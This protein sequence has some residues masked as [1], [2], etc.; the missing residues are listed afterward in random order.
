LT[1]GWVGS[2]ITADGTQRIEYAGA[3]YPVMARG[4][5]GWDIYAMTATAS[6]GWQRW[7][8]HV[9]RAVGASVGRLKRKGQPELEQL[10]RRP[11]RVYE[12]HNG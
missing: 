12:S 5:Q 2:G 3:A 10:K 1:G 6:C 9:R 7:T 8:K 11:E 4:N